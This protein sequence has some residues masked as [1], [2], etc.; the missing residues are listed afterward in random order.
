MNKHLI[1]IGLFIIGLIWSGIQPFDY[2]TWA[3][4]VFPAILGLIILI[5]TFKQ[6]QFTFLTY[7]FILFHSYILF[8]GG[9]YTYAE[10]PLFD[11]IKEVFDLSRNNY[12]KVGHFAQGFIP[13]MIVREIFVRNNIVTNKKWLNFIVVCICLSF[14]AIYEFLE[15]WVALFSGENAEAFLGTQGYVW[16]TQSDMFYATVGA[17]TMLVLLAKIQDKNISKLN[18]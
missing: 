1:L 2:F 5:F 6:F 4:E 17:I 16:D 8:I 15:W 3:L 14:S 7:C 11:W 12:D 18:N 13:A 10:V 9:H